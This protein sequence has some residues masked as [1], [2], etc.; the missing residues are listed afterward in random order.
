M[1]DEQ[2]LGLYFARDTSAID[3]TSTKYGVKLFRISQNMLSSA[4]DAEECVNDTYLGAWNAIPPEHPLYF[5]AFLAKLCR[6]LTCNR[7]DWLHAAK[8]HAPLIA[9]TEELENC[10]PDPACTRQLESAELG[11]LLSAFLRT[12]QKDSRLV[13]LRR[14]WYAESIREIAQRYAMSEGQVKS[15]L[16]R[17]RKKL[18]TYLE[19]EGIT[20]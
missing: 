11:T 8:R 4:Q 19:K 18:R 6:N 13:F 17:T 7:I 2:I 12:L 16:F 9:L 14:Y 5:F 20:V 15:L 10:L 1:E 3:E